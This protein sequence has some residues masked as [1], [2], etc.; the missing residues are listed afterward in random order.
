MISIY[1][2]ESHKSDVSNF[3]SYFD[4]LEN[5]RLRLSRSNFNRDN[6]RS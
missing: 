3:G 1:I 6:T 4:R 5:K 2:R